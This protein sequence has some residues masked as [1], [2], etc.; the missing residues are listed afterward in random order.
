MV[1]SIMEGMMILTMIIPLGRLDL[2]KE[3]DMVIPAS[4]SP[5]L[6]VEQVVGKEVEVH[7]VD[8]DPWL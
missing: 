6:D 3:R 2:M 1:I 7:W 4:V 8:L 5:W